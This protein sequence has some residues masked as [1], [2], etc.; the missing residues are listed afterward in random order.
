M[1]IDRPVKK[2]LIGYVK[3]GNKELIVLGDYQQSP[4]RETDSFFENISSELT[5]EQLS[6]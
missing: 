2:E 3:E 6:P 4:T 5:I 1:V